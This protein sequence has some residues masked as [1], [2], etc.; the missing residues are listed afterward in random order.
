MD[1]LTDVHWLSGQTYDHPPNPYFHKCVTFFEAIFY[2]KFGV[3][4]WID[5]HLQL[6]K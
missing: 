5:S 1:Q 6:L 2:L 3:G 4:H